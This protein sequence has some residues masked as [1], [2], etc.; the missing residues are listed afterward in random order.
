MAG[1]WL[2]ERVNQLSN[3]V[4]PV[5]PCSWNHSISIA[6]IPPI[7]PIPI[8][9]RFNLQ[10]KDSK[11]SERT[12]IPLSSALRSECFMCALIKFIYV[13]N[14]ILSP[15]TISRLDVCVGVWTAVSFIVLIPVRGRNFQNYFELLGHPI[16][17]PGF[18]F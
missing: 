8:S 9:T 7:P 4:F 18:L 16:A 12:F 2:N 14:V 1:L 5:C 10:F 13:T 15:T 11:M 17:L 6:L 3:L